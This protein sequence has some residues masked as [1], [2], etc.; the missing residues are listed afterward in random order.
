MTTLSDYPMAGGSATLN[1][2]TRT[3]NRSF[4][5]T[6]LPAAGFI[7]NLFPDS[8]SGLIY[9]LLPRIGPDTVSQTGNLAAQ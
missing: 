2:A 6:A 7:G 3:A 4:L 5:F 9:T 8:P 1:T